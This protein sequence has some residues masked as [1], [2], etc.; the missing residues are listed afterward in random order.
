MQDFFLQI[1]SENSA[2]FLPSP[3]AYLMHHKVQG[4][5]IV[6]HGSDT[7]GEGRDLYALSLKM[8]DEGPH[9]PL[10]GKTQPQGY[11]C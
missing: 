5:V 9:L 7:H 3:E 8:I 2:E 6:R 10:N 1:R 11:L 4:E